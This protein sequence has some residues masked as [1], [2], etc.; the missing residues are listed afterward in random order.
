VI[1][2]FR[3]Q[4]LQ[5]GLIRA[6]LAFARDRDC[7]LACASTAPGT[8]SQRSYEACGFHAAY[9]KVEMARG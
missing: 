3:G 6:R 2:R 8:A 9:P 1:P 5:K 7:D 4:G